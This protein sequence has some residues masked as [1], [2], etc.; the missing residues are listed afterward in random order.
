MEKVK[1][2]T[3]R[4]YQNIYIE[5]NVNN[6]FLSTDNIAVKDKPQ[7]NMTLYVLSVFATSLS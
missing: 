7:I 2:K 6:V 1:L 4:K 3:P 5:H